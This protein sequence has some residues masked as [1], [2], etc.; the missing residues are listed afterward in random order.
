M[1]I[2]LGRMCKRIIDYCR[3]RF[4]EQE[5]NALLKEKRFHSE[6]VY[7][8][9]PKDSTENCVILGCHFLNSCHS[10]DCCHSLN[11]YHGTPILPVEPGN[12]EESHPR[13]MPEGG[14]DCGHR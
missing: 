13:G 1:D 10:L 2:E 4:I 3:S 14:C 11:S 5:V 9:D 7:Y 8:C 6:L 12:R